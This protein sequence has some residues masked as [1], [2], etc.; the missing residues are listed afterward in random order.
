M[1]T[2]YLGRDGEATARDYLTGIG[3]EILASNVKLAGGEID[4]IARIGDTIAFIEV[5]RRASRA[6]GAPAEAV[7]PAKQK[8]IIRAAMVFCAKRN[9]M[10]EKLRFDVIELMPGYINHIESAFDTTNF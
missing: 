7:T 9:L 1:S 10:E 3:A 8:R 6:F 4:I 5:K 2:S